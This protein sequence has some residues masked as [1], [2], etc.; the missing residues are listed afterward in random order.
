[1]RIGEQKK[2]HR[3]ELLGDRTALEHRI[4]ADRHAAFK[5]GHAVTGPQRNRSVLRDPNCTAGRVSVE[6]GE[7][8]IHFR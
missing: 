7:D 2:G 4:G 8:V 1:L 5:I 6:G 3:G